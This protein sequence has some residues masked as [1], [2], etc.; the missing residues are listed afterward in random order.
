MTFHVSSKS[1]YFGIYRHSTTP[2]NLSLSYSVFSHLHLLS[3]FFLS[4]LL[5]TRDQKAEEPHAE[6]SAYE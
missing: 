6:C 3:L 4:L 1:T 5:R 2:A